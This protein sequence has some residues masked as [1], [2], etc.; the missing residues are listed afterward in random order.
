MTT[1]SATVTPQRLSNPGASRAK[2]LVGFGLIIAAI[3]YLIASNTLRNAQ[4]FFTVQELKE[5]GAGV[6]GRNVR[7]S[8]A[9]LGESI[10]Y[11]A[12]SLTL[13]F[14]VAN[15]TN[16]LNEIEA[17]GGLAQVLY[18]A[19][20]DPNATRLSVVYVGPK[21]DLMQAEAQAIVEG[22]LGEDGVFRADTLLLKCPTRYEEEVPAQ[23]GF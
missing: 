4:Y 14:T 12:Q 6:M 18:E 13:T 10:Q 16:D 3:I 5:Q 20:N 21:P 15:V 22:R 11:D 17:R 19:V 2:F 1:P 7:I 23:S 9:V 8:G